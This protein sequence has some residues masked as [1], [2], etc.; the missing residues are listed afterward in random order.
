M[1]S[2]GGVVRSTNAE[3]VIPNSAMNMRTSSSAA[4]IQFAV[5]RKTG[6]CLMRSVLVSLSVRLCLSTRCNE[7]QLYTMSV[8]VLPLNS[9]CA[10]NAS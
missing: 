2:T 10:F 8:R 4:I 9:L 1:E 7:A 6:V 5:C 3:T